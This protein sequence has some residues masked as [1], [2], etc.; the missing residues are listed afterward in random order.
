[1]LHSDRSMAD[2]AAKQRMLREAQALAQVSHPNV[3]SVFDVGVHED[4]VFIAMEL[5]DG[6]TLEEWLKLEER[7][8]EE[9][10]RVLSDAAAG[11]SAAHRVGMIHRDFKPQNVLIGSDGRVRVTDFG[12]AR[13]YGEE[14]LDTAPKREAAE[15]IPL[16]A[17]L[18]QTGHIAGTPAYMAPEQ[19]M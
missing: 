1:V 15:R 4:D 19:L 17:K 7:A 9:I 8:P 3:V 14:L 11:L 2:P 13:V 6:V 16:Q 12:L 10:V 18:T 5:I